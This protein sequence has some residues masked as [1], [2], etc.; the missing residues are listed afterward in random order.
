MN[1]GVCQKYLLDYIEKE[2]PD[3]LRQEVKLHLASCD[4]CRS[5]LTAQVQTQEVLSAEPVS[6]PGPAFWTNFLPGVRE[7]IEQQKSRARR[8]MIRRWAYATGFALVLVVAVV[9]LTRNGQQNAGSVT[10]FYHTT[11]DDLVDY[12]D[13]ATFDLSVGQYL[14]P[15]DQKI[16]AE[17]R[18]TV[19]QE[20]L[21]QGNL[22]FLLS[23]LP[24]EGLEQ[25][26]E[27]M[28]AFK[29]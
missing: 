14:S 24:D 21:A 12:I 29:L 5:E 9:L 4:L 1:C 15:A 2:L 23:G 18:A 3:S 6:E 19:Q 28:R 26:T 16:V 8:V 11:L 20:M 17:A 22:E 27:K 7:K 25:L 10:H 13:E